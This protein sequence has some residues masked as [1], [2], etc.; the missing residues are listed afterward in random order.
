MRS[1]LTFL[2]AFVV[3]FIMYSLFF[4]TLTERNSDHVPNIYSGENIS[5][6]KIK[7][8]IEQIDSLTA[9]ENYKFT[10]ANYYKDNIS[11]N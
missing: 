6:L 9:F 1:F 10:A 2:S 5:P 3:I 7:M 4:I 8:S 11:K